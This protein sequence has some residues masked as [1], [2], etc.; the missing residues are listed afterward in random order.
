MRPQISAFCITAKVRVV[1]NIYSQKRSSRNFRNESVC[2]FHEASSRRF[3]STPRSGIPFKPRNP[4]TT[5]LHL[6]VLNRQNSYT[7]YRAFYQHQMTLRCSRP[8][9]P[10]FTTSQQSGSESLPPITSP[11]QHYTV[12]SSPRHSQGTRHR[13][14]ICER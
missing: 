5:L 10:H 6:L 7:S 3:C 14:S 9:A 4:L 2:V 11:L 1:L 12:S 8:K 13:A